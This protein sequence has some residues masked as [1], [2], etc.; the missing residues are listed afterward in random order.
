[1]SSAELYVLIA[2]DK[3]NQAAQD[4]QAAEAALKTAQLNHQRQH[5]LGDEGLAS[6]RKVELAD[7]KLATTRSKRDAAK[8]KL[9]AA[10]RISRVAAR[11][12]GEAA[13]R[14]A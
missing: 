8:A 5:D 12:E 3:Q 4:L 7:L 9:R 2:K 11:R 6:T 14:Y 10:A 13:C 1:M